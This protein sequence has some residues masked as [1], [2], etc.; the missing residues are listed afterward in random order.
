MVTNGSY[1]SPQQALDSLYIH[2]LHP[3]IIV[4]VY[5]L[6]IFPC[7][8]SGD[9]K[10]TIKNSYQSCSSKVIPGRMSLL[11]TL[12]LSLTTLL[13]STITSSPPV[14]VGISALTAW[15]IIQYVFILAAILAY[16]FLLAFFRFADGSDER[17]KKTAKDIDRTYII[18]FPVVY[19]VIGSFY[20][21]VC[22]YSR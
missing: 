9:E 22:L 5:L 15:I 13:V 7:Q 16:A 21:A 2:L 17:K 10:Q 19:L 6:G 1:F 14:A 11:I 18:V 8:S 4:C 3:L 12:F 20:W